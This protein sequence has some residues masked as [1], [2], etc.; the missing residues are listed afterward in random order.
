M[1]KNLGLDASEPKSIQVALRPVVC[2]GL[3]SH[4]HL[5]CQSV[6][7]ILKTGG[8]YSFGSPGSMSCAASA[9][10]SRS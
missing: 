5:S 4:Q 7:A 2:T 1:P 3:C 6:S 10:F 9:A 8:G